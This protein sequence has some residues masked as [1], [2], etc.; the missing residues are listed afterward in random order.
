MMIVIVLIAMIV[1]MLAQH[2]GLTEAVASVL[3]KIAKCHRCV[4]FWV[5]LIALALCCCNPLIAVGLSLIN[6][7]L[8][9]WFGLLLIWLNHKYNALWE[10]LNK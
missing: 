1:G 9:N 10:K 8:S 7:Y 3:S 2:L 4:V 5:T 6:S